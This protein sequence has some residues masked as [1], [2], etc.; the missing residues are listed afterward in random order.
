MEKRNQLD[1]LR[2]TTVTG[3][4]L[5]N[6]DLSI[7]KD[8]AVTER[9]QTEFRAEFFN[10][11]NHANWLLTGGARDFGNSAFGTIQNTMDPRIVQ[12]GLKL[13]F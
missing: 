5:I 8:T 7:R 1:S 4:G 11:P 9:I 10:A 6:W 12:F 2:R 13:R 3:P